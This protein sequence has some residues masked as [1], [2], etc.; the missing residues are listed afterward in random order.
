MLSILANKKIPLLCF[1]FVLVAAFVCVQ[2]KAN[3]L[4]F[5][6]SM[7]GTDSYMRMHQI[8]RL[9]ETGDWFDRSYPRSNAPYGGEGHWSRLP[10]ILMIAAAHI[11]SLFTSLNEAFLYVYKAYSPFFLL[12]LSA[13]LLYVGRTFLPVASLVGAVCLMWVFPASQKFLFMWGRPDYHGMQAFFLFASF[14]HLLRLAISGVKRHDAFWAGLLCAL[15][16]WTSPEALL[17][18]LT[19]SLSFGLLWL[20]SKEDLTRAFTLFFGSVFSCLLFFFLIERPPS[21]YFFPEYDRLS[22]VH[23]F[24]TASVFFSFL[25]S[26]RL[27]A[28]VE[29]LSVMRKRIYAATATVLSVALLMWLVFPRFFYGPIEVSPRIREAFIS[30]VYDMQNISLLNVGDRSFI[31]IFTFLGLLSLGCCLLSKERWKQSFALTWIPPF[32]IYMPLGMLHIRLVP[33]LLIVLALPVALLIGTPLR[34]KN[35][36]EGSEKM[37]VGTKLLLV[38]SSLVVLIVGTGEYAPHFRSESCPIRPFIPTLKSTLE[39]EMGDREDVTLMANPFLGPELLWRTPYAVVGTPYTRNT[40]G[41]LAVHD[42]VVN[43]EKYDAF[44]ILKERGVDYFLLCSRFP[45]EMSSAPH[46]QNIFPWDDGKKLAFLF[47]MDALPAWLVQRPVPDDLRPHYRLARFLPEKAPKEWQEKYA[48][49]ALKG[50][51]LPEQE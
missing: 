39:K 36:E 46:F 32:L 44:R 40:Q 12:L 27:L 8:D 13:H 37:G 5:G 29:G 43:I 38:Y 10:D 24:L 18:Y 2:G 30:V 15:G 14:I 35:R 41:F 20:H 17:H 51:E 4:S 45:L 7:Y 3:L 19:L 42:T 21:E 49:D 33:T 48:E 50:R 11:G 34:R 31:F 28:R 47:A 22:V 25:L 23:L 9:L 6:D 16:L 1:A 26:G